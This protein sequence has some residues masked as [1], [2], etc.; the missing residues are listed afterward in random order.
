MIFNVAVHHTVRTTAL[1]M[2]NSLRGW[3]SVVQ[4]PIWTQI[5]H[6]TIWLQNINN[7]NQKQAMLLEELFPST[8][9]TL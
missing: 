5:W 8:K 2:S 1:L 4:A 3:I 7:T 9:L 6:Q